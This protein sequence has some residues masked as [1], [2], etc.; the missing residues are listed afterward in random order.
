MGFLFFLGTVLTKLSPQQGPSLGKKEDN[1][2]KTAVL[3]C[4]A[5]LLAFASAAQAYTVTV[6]NEMNNTDGLGIQYR[7]DMDL[8]YYSYKAALIQP[9]E[10]WKETY[11]GISIGICFKRFAIRVKQEFSGCSGG[12]LTD[13]W[14]EKKGTWCR[15]VTVR[16]KRYG[17]NLV[18]EVD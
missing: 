10:S 5:I 4:V 14:I 6:K 3:F 2:L 18:I 1:M 9:G 13:R 12:N 16:A 8:G 17:C 7:H 15:N 11:S